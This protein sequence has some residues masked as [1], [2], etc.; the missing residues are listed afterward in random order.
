MSAVMQVPVSK[1]ADEDM[2]G[3]PAALI[4][5]GQRAREIAART[6][7]PLIIREN[8]V[9][10]RKVITL[11][12]ITTHSRPAPI[13]NEQQGYSLVELAVVMLIVAL[14]IGGLLLPLS[15]QQEI[16][17]RQETERIL[18]NAR[19]VLLGF[20]ALNERLPC[21]ATEN[22]NGRETFCS[23]N[24]YPCS[25]IVEVYTYDSATNNGTCFNY[26]K[27]FLPAVTLGIQPIDASGFAVDGWATSDA[28]R[29][30]YA[31]STNSLRDYGT[32]IPTPFVLTKYQGMKDATIKADLSV[33]TGGSRVINTGTSTKETATGQN[34]YA[35]CQTGY[36]L[37]EDAVGVIYS[38]GKNAST[39]GTDDDERHNPNP[40]GSTVAD[41]AFV[42]TTLG[43]TFDDSV[44]WI[45]ANLLFGRMVA[46]GK[47]P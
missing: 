36:A 43:T 14:L 4:R 39:G 28:N 25:A 33:C 17:S 29:L 20:A 23:T 26:Y 1:L 10:V 44:T 22:S 11:D 21:P 3:A 18:A 40:Q 24:D 34:N 41:P 7:T 27:G 46:A 5:A 13:N 32:S 31:V 19:E 30:R 47:L 9:I 12:M 45:S 16:R 8:G 35:R 2:Q 37:V 42:Y 38:L 15:A 6:G